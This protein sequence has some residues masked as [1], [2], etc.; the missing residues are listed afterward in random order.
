[1]PVDDIDVRFAYPEDGEE[2]AAAG[3]DEAVEPD[4]PETGG[5]G[6]AAQQDGH[7]LPR[8]GPEHKTHYIHNT[9]LK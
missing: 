2:A 1:M 8:P 7:L 9:T 6:G 5:D 3:E 4:A